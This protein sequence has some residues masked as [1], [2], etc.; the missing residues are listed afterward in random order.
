ML[1]QNHPKDFKTPIPYTSPTRRLYEEGA[2]R[3]RISSSGVL[4][5]RE[6]TPESPIQSWNETAESAFITFLERL[7]A[8]EFDLPVYGVELRC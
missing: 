4:S 8:I 5:D 7:N 6:D 1:I 3:D 2:R